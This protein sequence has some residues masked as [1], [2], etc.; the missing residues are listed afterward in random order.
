MRE[1]VDSHTS[2]TQKVSGSRKMTIPEM[3]VIVSSFFQKCASEHGIYLNNDELQKE[4]W[5][6]PGNKNGLTW[7]ALR[8][9]AE[10][11]ASR[12][13]FF[14][15]EDTLEFEDLISQISYLN[16]RKGVFEKEG[17]Y[18]QCIYC[19]R[20]VPIVGKSKW[21][22]CDK[23][24]QG[25]RDPEIRKIMRLQDDIHVIRPKVLPYICI[26]SDTLAVTVDKVACPHLAKFME[27]GRT[28][29]EVCKF[30]DIHID[31]IQT[32]ELTWAMATYEAWHQA[33]EGDKGIPTLV[34]DSDLPEI[35]DALWERMNR[36]V[37]SAPLAPNLLH[38]T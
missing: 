7:S 2:F 5:K 25:S 12:C 26:A 11:I 13:L 30:L 20:Y 15:Y 27:R 21:A 34:Q 4:L 37:E 31:E 38:S 28:R 29:L 24:S 1:I 14:S 36:P 19:W 6:W 22:V 17:R 23:H 35:D 10:K 33:H 16:G 3:V 32:Y 18:G 9:N 8:L